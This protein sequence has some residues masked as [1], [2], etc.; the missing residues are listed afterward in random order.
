METSIPFR[1]LVKLV[2]AQ[3]ITNEKTRTLDLPLE[4]DKKTS[5]LESQNL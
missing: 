4:M 1:R 3:G 5:T 2:D